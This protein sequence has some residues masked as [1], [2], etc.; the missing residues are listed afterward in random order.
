MIPQPYVEISLRPDATAPG[1]ARD[2]LDDL[3]QA[4]PE[5][6]ADDVR[7]LVTEYV[8]NAVKYAGLEPEEAIDL[9]V[10]IPREG[11]TRQGRV[12]VLVR[13]PEHVGFLRPTLPLQAGEDSE[14]GLFLVDQISDRW[15]V[16]QTNGL[17]E[18]WFEIDLQQP[19]SRRLERMANEVRI[20]RF[21]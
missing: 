3:M 8:T 21:R 1:R 14:W 10:R 4:L 12:E 15:S 13:Y 7:L 6:S 2:R 17:M 19:R 20:P 9:V 16:V 5:A 11:R 18:T